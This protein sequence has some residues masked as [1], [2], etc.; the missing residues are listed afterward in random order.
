MAHGFKLASGRHQ[1]WESSRL[2][3]RFVC[4]ASKG[5]HLPQMEVLGEGELAMLGG[6]CPL[7]PGERS[8]EQDSIR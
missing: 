6:C 2:G 5:V 4:V 3:I 8:S 7:G 1:V